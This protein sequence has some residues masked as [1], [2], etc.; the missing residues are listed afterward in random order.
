MGRLR[1]YCFDQSCRPTAP[2]IEPDDGVTLPVAI[3]RSVGQGAVNLR[4]DVLTIQQ[5]LNAVG[6]GQGRPTLPLATDGLFGPLTRAAIGNFQKQ[7]I[8][9][10]DFRIDSNGPTIQA[11]NRVLGGSS[12]AP[13]FNV[14]DEMMERVFKDIMPVSQACVKSALRTLAAAR[15]MGTIESPA[16]T[17]VRK[18]FAVLLSDPPP[19]DFALIERTF[20]A[21][22]RQFSLATVI[23]ELIFI[24]FP[25]TLSYAEMAEA[26]ALAM[27]LMH[28][29]AEHGQTVKIDS[30]DGST[31]ATLPADAVV[32]LPVYFFADSDLQIGT[33][34]HE[35][36][37][38]VGQPEGDPDGI[39]DP[40]GN[41]SSDEA[42]ALLPPQQR[43]RIAECYSQF[44]FEAHFGRSMFRALIKF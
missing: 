1:C 43:P 26:R 32:L 30:R 8:G 21:I 34:I 27:S 38:F 35:L 10:V 13:T 12:P 11:L 36:G 33:L 6:I 4:D 29:V 28:G 44:A 25:F 37:H 18:H 39:D 16:Q 5:A 15:A 23:P 31:S 2:R 9:F 40:P 41:S 19:P 20:R 17:L 3:G 24:K 22:D 42:L 14:T 7:N